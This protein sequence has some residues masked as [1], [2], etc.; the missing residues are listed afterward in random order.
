MKTTLVF[1]SALACIQLVGARLEQKTFQWADTPCPT[2]K[3]LSSRFV[4]Q[5]LLP[6]KSLPEERSYARENQTR[7]IT[8][9]CL[10][11][12]SDYRT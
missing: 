11:V 5:V 2:A 12:G 10:L 3:L 9:L 1:F 4:I 8:L 7:L 6:K